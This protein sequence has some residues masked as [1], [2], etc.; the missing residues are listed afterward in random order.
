MGELTREPSCPDTELE[1]GLTVGQPFD[2]VGGRAGVGRE[3]VPRVVDV[4]EGFAVSVYRK[5]GGQLS[6]TLPQRW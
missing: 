5:V 3:R 1:H 2:Q 6:R 4:G